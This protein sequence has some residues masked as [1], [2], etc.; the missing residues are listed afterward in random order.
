MELDDVSTFI[1]T[2]A[3]VLGKEQSP[4]SQMGVVNAFPHL[5]STSEQEVN[6]KPLRQKYQLQ[7]GNTAETLLNELNAL[8]RRSQDDSYMAWKAE[9]SSLPISQRL[10]IM[11][12]CLRRRSAAGS[13][14][15]FT[16]VA[17]DSYRE[18]FS[19]QFTNSFGAEQFQ[20]TTVA[21]IGLAA[22]TFS[23]ELVAQMIIRSPAGK[24]PGISGIS[25]ELLHPVAS[26]LAPIFSRLFRVYM[27]LSMVPYSWKRALMCPVPKKGDLSRIANYRPISLTELTM[28]RFEMCLLERMC[29]EIR[30]S[31]KQ[32][33][34]RGNRS[35]LDQIEYLDKLI[36]EVRGPD[37]RRKVFMAFLDI[38][39]YDSVPRAEL[40]RQCHSL[41][42][43]HL[44]LS[45]LRALFDHNSAQLF[46]AQKRSRPFPL[47]AGVLQGS[48][49]SHL[50]YSIYLDP[51]YRRNFEHRPQDLPPFETGYGRNKF[52]DVC[53][54]HCLNFDF[55]PQSCST[56]TPCR[57]RF[58][59][60]RLPLQSGSL[61]GNPCNLLHL[62]TVLI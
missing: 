50:L 59:G 39:A 43:D 14:L 4:W 30:L 11:N 24:A 49:L 20:E 45:T 38:K 55:K 22:Q 60:T 19:G 53:R 62:R 1:K 12:R 29:S 47:P 27:S 18:H 57:A 6:L 54:R 21:E 17:L 42:V 13:C 33:G 48:V 58:N 32:G 5:K 37:R 25:A 2:A 23:P 26:E 7:P 10:K 51:H 28:K 35:T 34:F 52:L 44:T 40:W 3:R 15:S 8:D 56:L 36:K 31:R 9:L 16:S 41:G 46:V 61:A